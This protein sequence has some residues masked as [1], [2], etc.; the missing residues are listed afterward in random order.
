MRARVFSHSTAGLKS[1]PPC[2][3]DHTQSPGCSPEWRDHRPS[4]LSLSRVPLKTVPVTVGSSR[5]YA[6]DAPFVTHVRK[7]FPS[8][9]TNTSIMHMQVNSCSSIMPSLLWLILIT[10]TVACR[11]QALPCSFVSLVRIAQMPWKGCMF[12]SSR[13]LIIICAGRVML[14]ARGLSTK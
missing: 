3:R 7:Y 14:T 11:K 2:A 4:V 5:F 13:H 10:S 6:A 1:V 9:K 8:A 12:F